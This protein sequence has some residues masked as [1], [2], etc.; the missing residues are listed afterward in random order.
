M[1]RQINEYHPVIGHRYIPGIQARMPHESGG[2]LVKTNSSGFRCQHEFL[3]EKPDK[4]FRV[5]LFGDSFTAGDGVSNKYRFGDL[6]EQRVSGLE[7]LNFGLSGTGTD[8]QYLA[9]E[10]YGS[11]LTYD[12][13]LICPLV[14]NIKR[15]ASRYETIIT[16][17]N[18]DVG[19][20][21][22]PYFELKNDELVLRNTPVAKGVMGREELEAGDNF[23]ANQGIVERVLR[24]LVNRYLYPVKNLLQRTVAYDPVS[25]YSDANGDEWKLMKRILEDWVKRADGVPVVICPIPLYHHVEELSSPVNYQRRFAELSDGPNVQILD[26]L[27]KFWEESRETRRQCRFEVD[28]H[29]T[30]LGHSIMADALMPIIVN[31][32]KVSEK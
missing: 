32:M 22:K 8:Q 18:G 21:A 25:E 10:H 16:R 4:T 14:Q 15:V 30:Q 23:L 2:Y 17:D 3:K 24:G 13:L 7:V 19:F 11:D 5:L 12:L 9:Y 28:Q 27:H 6:L 26:P 31:S 20:I 29:F 1:V